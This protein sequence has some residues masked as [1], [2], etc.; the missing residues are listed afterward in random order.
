MCSAIQNIRIYVSIKE[1]K[2]I[3]RRGDKADVSKVF[4]KDHNIKT[5]IEGID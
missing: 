1:K 5:G 3:D 4:D 2:V